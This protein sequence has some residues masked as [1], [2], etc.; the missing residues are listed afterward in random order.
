MQLLFKKMV[1]TGNDFIMIDNRKGLFPVGDK[2]YISRICDR[3]CGV[4]SDGV[5]LLENSSKAD[6]RMRIINPDGGE[7][8]MC[9]NGSRCAVR[10]AR[11][12]G[13]FSKEE[14][15]FETIAGVLKGRISKDLVR[16]TMGQARDIRKD[17]EIRIDGKPVTVYFLN[18]GVP[19][20]VMFVDDVSAVDVF[21]WGRLIRR[22]EKFQPAGTNANF[23]QIMDKETI[24]VRTY[25]RG[26][27]DETYS[28]GTG[29][30]ACAIM[31]HLVKGTGRKIRSVTAR[32][33]N[34][35]VDF[36]TDTK[37]QPGT[38]YLSGPA[39]YVFEGT[40]EYAKP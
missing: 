8:E 29:T 40:I 35:F 21:N 26:V 3:R 16:I 25:E 38:F 36:E 11:D 39:E 33:E 28:C 13:F 17:I 34:L 14:A 27:E 23:V 18:T 32:N 37:G 5:I 12:L 10:L 1:G 2:A 7:V 6:F 30:C 24:K 31:A 15:S 19:H 4:G 20:V 22:H 9:G